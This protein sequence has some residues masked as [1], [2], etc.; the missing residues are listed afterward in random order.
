MHV[1]PR[2][3]IVVNLCIYKLMFCLVQLRLL[4]VKWL[5]SWTRLLNNVFS[6]ILEVIGCCSMLSSSNLWTNCKFIEEGVMSFFVHKTNYLM[7]MKT[8]FKNKATLKMSKNTLWFCVLSS[9]KFFPNA[10]IG[11]LLRFFWV[12][13]WIFFPSQGTWLCFFK[14]SWLCSAPWTFDQWHT[15]LWVFGPLLIKY[16]AMLQ[17]VNLFNSS[18]DH[19]FF[20]SS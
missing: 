13:Y 3:V 14:I 2:F 5:K 7:N 9:W 1:P 19:F 17:S 20:P 15:L 6:I 18:S 16:L 10:S 4:Q 11:Y 8:N 12:N